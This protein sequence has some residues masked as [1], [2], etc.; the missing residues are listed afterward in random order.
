MSFFDNI[1]ERIYK[2]MDDMADK[3]HVWG[4]FSR[5]HSKAIL[6]LG[7][8]FLSIISIMA[9]YADSSVLYGMIFLS[10]GKWVQSLI[11]A[12]LGALII[13]TLVAIPTNSL[14]IIL[15]KGLC[16]NTIKDAKGETIPNTKKI[17]HIRQMVML[18]IL[19]IIGL[20]STLYLSFNTDKLARSQSSEL[21]TEIRESNDNK[22]SLYQSQ[23]IKDVNIIASNFTKDSSSILTSYD[24]QIK[25][26]AGK[27]G[28]KLEA[29]MKTL[30]V[31]KNEY[32]TTK[33]LKEKTKA[34][35][36]IK[37]LE[38]TVIPNLQKT[39]A[40]RTKDLELE[41]SNALSA[42]VYQ[43][44]NKLN[45]V[46]RKYE[47]KDSLQMAYF[48]NNV[49]TLNSDV[50][51]LGSTLQGWNILLNLVIAIC[52]A[53]RQ[54]FYIGTN[55]DVPV[56]RRNYTNERKIRNTQQNK[57]FDDELRT[58]EENMKT[59]RSTPHPN[60]MAE[61]EEVDPGVVHEKIKSQSGGFSSNKILNTSTSE[62]STSQRLNVSTSKKVDLNGG[63]VEVKPFQ[64]RGQRSEN[65][66]LNAPILKENPIEKSG[67][68]STFT[69]GIVKLRSKNTSTPN[70]SQ[71][72]KK[73]PKYKIKVEVALS[74]DCI[75]LKLIRD[76]ISGLESNIGATKS[77]LTNH[78]KGFDENKFLNLTAIN[79][80]DLEKLRKKRDKLIKNS[81][82]T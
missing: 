30:E 9:I 17:H 28:I 13:W 29:K 37:W 20:G 10:T 7:F 27:Y 22:E 79:R 35:Q 52:V 63:R 46:Y 1:N 14:T 5:L 2:F 23:K 47:V 45:S 34:A 11:A 53:G 50:D 25:A 55:E 18:I 61:F 26:K 65:I 82:Y 56:K 59:I 42:L 60:D 3:N 57:D 6:I 24:S 49:N 73:T 81:K 80:S 67:E 74:K 54:L 48:S 31:L 44:D 75:D 78:K 8:V 32:K 21:Q 4:D 58:T 41:K 19:L 33:D 66:D 12:I 69:Q 16:R 68:T 71:K 36:G 77:R 62:T 43:K 72:A 39:I 70:V 76:A 40:S 15:S 51:D 38:L 64:N